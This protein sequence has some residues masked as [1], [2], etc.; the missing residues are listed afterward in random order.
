MSSV[1]KK[2]KGKK[3]DNAGT[4]AL[5]EAIE[6]LAPNCDG[7]RSADGKGFNKLDSEHGNRLAAM[8]NW[9]RRHR[10]QAL[11]LVEIY[12]KQLSADLLN[13]VRE[14]NRELYA[15]IRRRSTGWLRLRANLV[16]DAIKARAH[17]AK[18]SGGQLYYYYYR[19]GVYLPGG[20]EHISRAVKQVLHAH[21]AA[22]EWSI[23]I[24]REVTEYIRV[25]TLKLCTEPLPDLVNLKNGVLNIKSREL[26]EHDPGFLSPIQIPV[27]YDPKADCPRWE[28]FIK[29]IFPKDAQDL[30][31]EI[32]GHLLVPDT[33]LQKA[34]LLLGEGGE[35]Q[36]HVF[37]RSD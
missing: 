9:A 30:A 20:E 36:E 13:K 10:V 12:H 15:S 11:K 27:A 5:R 29:Q 16:A 19:L 28:R 34:F 6:Q 18:D 14:T 2:R 35:R 31:W 17:F 33:S 1:P 32:I 26:E 21:G 7:A 8:D 23:H 4:D 3:V 25:N 22:D 24:V 37:E